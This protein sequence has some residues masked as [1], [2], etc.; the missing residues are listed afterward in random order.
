MSIH[1][2]KISEGQP[3]NLSFSHQ[4]SI[5]QQFEP[6]HKK[7]GSLYQKPSRTPNCLRVKTDERESSAILKNDN[8]N[9]FAVS[10]H[11][12]N[13]ASKLTKTRNRNVGGEPKDPRKAKKG[14]HTV[15][16]INLTKNIEESKLKGSS[17]VTKRKQSSV[18]LGD[19]IKEKI[20][21][22]KILANCLDEYVREERRN[23]TE[24]NLPEI[25]KIIGA[26]NRSEIAPISKPLE[27]LIAQIVASIQSSLPQPQ[28]KSILKK[29]I[30]FDSP[31]RH[32]TEQSDEVAD[33]VKKGLGSRDLGQ[34]KEEITGDV[35]KL[36]ENLGKLKYESNR[37]KYFFEE[38]SS[39]GQDEKKRADKAR[40][41]QEKREELAR[42][43]EYA[44]M[45][46]RM[47]REMEHSS[48]DSG[49]YR[50]HSP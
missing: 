38:I 10:M 31:N 2:I 3:N 16:V 20:E 22:F 39:K 4:Q 5:N 7:K 25:I 44:E 35:R 18:D 21:D 23:H 13:S 42:L 50:S 37:L 48:E 41:E 28:L 46:A 45:Q 17:T 9:S 32:I 26:F 19:R 14:K 29:S 30:S 43:K 15:S 34:K 33:T 6:R 11:L 47:I 27:H 1:R 12:A 49:T 40:L 8:L 24:A 36:E